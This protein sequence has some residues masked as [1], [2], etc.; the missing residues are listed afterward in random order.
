MA[1]DPSK[2]ALDR[3]R[4]SLGR[5]LRRKLSQSADNIKYVRHLAQGHKVRSLGTPSAIDA[6]PVVLLHGFLGTRGTLEPLTHTLQGQG[7]P[8]FSY[9][10]GQLSTRS[11]EESARTLIEHLRTMKRE[12]GT[13]RVDMVGYSMGGIVGLH[14]LKQLGAARWARSL[15]MLGSPVHGTRLGWAGIA[16]MGAISDSVWQVL[17]NSRYLQ[18]LRQRPLPS[19]V[20]LCQ[21][22]AHADRFC[23]VSPK[24]DEVA[25]DDYHLIEGVHASLLV[26]QHSH[27]LVGD[28]LAGND[29]LTP[30]LDAEIAE[31]LVGARANA[32]KL[33]SPAADGSPGTIR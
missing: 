32:S 19:G 18:T 33:Q 4:P 17:P 7:R 5:R 8:V 12:L 29:A 28:L 15:I 9:A 27:G 10:L 13:A 30:H 25:S 2:L 31:H 26:S 16:A 23:P 24:L 6:R 22:H 3:S 11:F 14:A 1:Q 21:V 20:R